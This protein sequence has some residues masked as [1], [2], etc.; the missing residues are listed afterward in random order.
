MPIF[1]FNYG[2]NVPKMSSIKRSLK[3]RDKAT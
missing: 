3:A 1:I 2:A